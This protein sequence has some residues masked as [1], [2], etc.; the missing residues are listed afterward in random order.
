M[1]HTLQAEVFIFSRKYLFP[2]HSNARWPLAVT[3][4]ATGC[5]GCEG[6]SLLN[7]LGAMVLTVV[8]V[9]ERPVGAGG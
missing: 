1:L 4:A 3:V 2:Q 5:C 9:R 8:E 7:S 6:H